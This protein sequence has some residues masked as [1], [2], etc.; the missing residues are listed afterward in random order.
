[1]DTNEIITNDEVILAAEEIATASSGK[2]FN[3]AVGIG[4]AILIGVVAYKYV[5]KPIMAKIKAKR[6][7]QETTFVA[8]DTNECIDDVYETTE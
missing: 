2:S 6:N 5:A 1:M 7:Q 8:E 3:K 4:L